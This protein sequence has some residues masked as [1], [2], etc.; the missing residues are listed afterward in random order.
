MLKVLLVVDRRFSEIGGEWYT[1]GPVGSETGEKYLAYFEKVAVVGR[2]GNAESVEPRRMSPVDPRI[3]VSCLPNL[4][5]VAGQIRLATVVR[6]QL[7]ALVSSADAVI[8]RMPT[9]LGFVAARIAQRQGVPLAG[10][11]GA[12]AFDGMW[13]HGSVTGRL[14]APFRFL[15]ARR[16]IRSCEYVNFV[17]QEY[18]QARYPVGSAV[19]LGCSDVDLPPLRPEVF[20]ARIERIRRGSCPLRFGTVGSLVG[21]LKGIHLAI[22]ALGDLRSELPPFEYR[23]LGGG[24]PLVLQQLAEQCGIGD[25]VSFDGTLPAGQAVLEWLDQIDLYIHPSLRE[26]VS[27]AIIEAMSRA[28]PIIASSVAGTPELL[29][30]SVLHRPGDVTDLRRRIADCAT[31]RAWQETQARQNFGA[32]QR[33]TREVLEPKRAAFWRAFA[34]TARARKQTTLGRLEGS[35]AC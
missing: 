19:T 20:A 2:A 16:A 9:E 35:P 7:S 23:V 22:R 10:D 14:Y 15:R 25:R 4:A 30:R 32:A 1:S 3:E 31:D 8:V 28:C 12:C 5:S 18:L 33:Y 29:P 24:N 26:G 13:Q 17:T 11:V 21:R 27:R 34:D 6:R